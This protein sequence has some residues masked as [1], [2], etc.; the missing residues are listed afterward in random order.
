MS[1]FLQDKHN[2]NTVSLMINFMRIRLRSKTQRLSGP[3]LHSNVLASYT[4]T[5][6]I[7][8]LY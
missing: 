5:L 7:K 4:Q 8:T 3:R 2:I 6:Y 1:L